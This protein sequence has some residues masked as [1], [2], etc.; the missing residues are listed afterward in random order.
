MV[1]PLGKIHFCAVIGGNVIAGD[2]PGGTALSSA[3]VNMPGN[4]TDGALFQS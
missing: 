1:R 4:R 3:A 2:P